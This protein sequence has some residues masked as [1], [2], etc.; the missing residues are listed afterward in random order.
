MRIRRLFKHGTK[1]V[2]LCCVISPALQSCAEEAPDCKPE[3]ESLL[4]D[5]ARAYSD[6]DA[7]RVLDFYSDYFNAPGP[8]FTK[9]GLRD[10]VERLMRSSSRLQVTYGD[11]EILCAGK[12]AVANVA[13]EFKRRHTDEDDL[14]TELLN[15]QI[16]FERENDQWKIDEFLPIDPHAPV[17]ALAPIQGRLHRRCLEGEPGSYLCDAGRA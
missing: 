17:P 1:T 16:R 7:E 15:L 9:K 13:V 10:D 11:A 12:L 3:L 8:P 5:L 4:K 14:E 6:R 2:F